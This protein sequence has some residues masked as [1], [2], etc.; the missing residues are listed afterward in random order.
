MKQLVQVKPGGRCVALLLC[1][2]GQT[3]VSLKVP[4]VRS[5]EATLKSIGDP[6]CSWCVYTNEQAKLKAGLNVVPLITMK[7]ILMRKIM[8][9]GKSQHSVLNIR[10]AQLS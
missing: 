5:S 3:E 9:Q 2:E 10:I 8:I 4:G 1:P 7:V 6:G